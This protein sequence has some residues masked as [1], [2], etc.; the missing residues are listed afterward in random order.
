MCGL[1]KHAAGDDMACSF[2]ELVFTGCD[3]RAVRKKETQLLPVLSALQLMFHVL[4][5]SMT[6][7]RKC[8]ETHLHLVR[9]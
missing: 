8:M 4:K 6:A 3:V 5:I 1:S 2:L 9:F 7:V